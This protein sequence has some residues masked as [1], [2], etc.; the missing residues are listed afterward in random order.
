M[1]RQEVNSFCAS[2][3]LQGFLSAFLKA[4]RPYQESLLFFERILEEFQRQ[5]PE[6][7]V[8]SVAAEVLREVVMKINPAL[9]ALFSKSRS[10]ENRR[11]LLK[12]T[13]GLNLPNRMCSWRRPLMR[14]VVRLWWAVDWASSTGL[15]RAKSLTIFQRPLLVSRANSNARGRN[16]SV[17]NAKRK[18]LLGSPASSRKRSS[19]A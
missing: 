5:F 1:A 16:Y 4:R 14:D 7:A 9:A 19:S 18:R 2:G 17:R 10:P 11:L 15:A 8:V 6:P 3:F 12:R 13:G